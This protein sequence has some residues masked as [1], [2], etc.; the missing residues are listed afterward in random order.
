M[1]K[2]DSIV[3]RFVLKKNR[4]PKKEQQLLELWRCAFT[5]PRKTLIKNLQGSAYRSDELGH[6]LMNL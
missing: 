3:L 6:I 1:P 2:V 5:H 4:D